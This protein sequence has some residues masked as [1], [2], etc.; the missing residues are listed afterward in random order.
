M[1][2][3]LRILPIL[4]LSTYHS[5]TIL[6]FDHIEHLN[7]SISEKKKLLEIYKLGYSYSLLEYNINLYVGKQVENYAKF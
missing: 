4:F 3:H 6:V 1:N 5:L 2:L 7:S